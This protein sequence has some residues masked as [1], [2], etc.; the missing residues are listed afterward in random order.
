MTALP[1][2][3]RAG[4]RTLQDPLPDEPAK[5][6][7]ASDKKFLLA[8]YRLA[9]DYYQPKIENHTNTKLGKI[10]ICDYPQ[11]REHRIE[12]FIKS[13]A[14]RSVQDFLFYGLH[15]LDF[16]TGGL[17]KRCEKRAQMCLATYFENAIYVSISPGSENQ[18]ETWFAEI[19]VHELA[20]SLWYKLGGPKCQERQR[21][22]QRDK[23]KLQIFCEG[24]A[25]FAQ[26]VWFR[27]MYP[28][29]ERIE[30]GYR[31]WPENSVY[32]QGVRKIRQIVNEH[33]PD[34]LLEIPSRWQ[35]F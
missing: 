1:T 21:L 7:R 27:D 17:T 12:K 18:H 9:V 23:E 33:G 26:S 13:P 2:A 5:E 10:R 30:V 34:I 25:T 31:W 3:H 6:I 15:C 35:D 28:L 22:S 4:Y 20:H 14:L 8:M 19:V 16:I 24:Y 29:E 11:L 32:E